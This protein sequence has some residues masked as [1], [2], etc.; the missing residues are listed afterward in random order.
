YLRVRVRGNGEVM[1]VVFDAEAPALGTKI[2]MD[3]AFCQRVAIGIAEK[4][5]EDF[6]VENGV[7]Y[8]PIDIEK[9][10]VSALPSPFEH[11]EPES[12]IVAADRHMVGNNIDEHAHVVLAQCRHQFAKAGFTAKFGID[13]AVIDDVVTVQ[14]TA[15]G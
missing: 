4:W 3:I 1:L 5:R 15:T 14:R 11:I 8:L 9:I 6:V 2:Q 7:R 13:G 10:G 12:I